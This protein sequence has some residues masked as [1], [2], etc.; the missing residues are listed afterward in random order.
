MPK[1]YAEW[2]VLRHFPIEKHEENLW[3]V[4]GT[5]PGMN[6]K[7]VMTLVRLEDGAIVVHSAIALDEDSM[8][9]IEA[10]GRPGVLLVPNAYHRLDAP[11][12]A[13]R[14]PEI[15]VLC[16]EGG[17]CKIEEVVR[18]DGTYDD[19]PADRSLTL[20]HLEGVGRA[21]GILTIR[22]ASGTTLV[23]NDALFNLPH[24]AGLTGFIFR[25]ITGS[26]GGP[27]VTRV[28][29]WFVVK[30]RAA[31]ATHLERLADT[32]DLRRIVVSH[33]RAITERP[34]EVLRQVADTLT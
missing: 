15:R 14:Y 33:G 13:A 16:P 5:L 24:G 9:E 23:F 32:P 19:F 3:C 1:A 27:R 17:R 11:A 8:S 12:F 6:L 2:T 18:V 31:L 30:D 10:W 7:R 26:T 25:Y 29:R 28:V 22:S 4:T 21:E 34:A 20:E